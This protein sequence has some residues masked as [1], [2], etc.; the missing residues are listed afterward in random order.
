[1]SSQPREKTVGFVGLGM[2]GGPMAENI[3]KKGHPLVAYDIDKQ[4][5]ERFVGL[6][7]QAGFGPGRR[8]A[9]REQGYIDG[10]YD[11]AG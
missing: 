2:M 7:A 6:G 10:R 5:L 9:A 3:L 11:R 1:M 8:R 4:K